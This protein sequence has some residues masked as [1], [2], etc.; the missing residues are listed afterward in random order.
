MWG[1]ER[2]LGDWVIPSFRRPETA[3]FLRARETALSPIETVAGAIESVMSGRRESLRDEFL[4]ALGVLMH[5]VDCYLA[6]AELR[7]LWS[8]RRKEL[9]TLGYLGV[10]Y[11]DALHFASLV[12]AIPSLP[13]RLV[14]VEPLPRF[15]AACLKT[16]ERLQSL[17]PKSKDVI[18][19][20]ARASAALARRVVSLMVSVHK[21]GSARADVG[22]GRALVRSV[23]ALR[24]DRSHDS[25]LE[26]LGKG[27]VKS[28]RG[29]PPC[30]RRRWR[31]GRSIPDHRHSLRLEVEH[32]VLAQLQPRGHGAATGGGAA[33]PVEVKGERLRLAGALATALLPSFGSSPRS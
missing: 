21:R 6:T 3:F 12:T 2:L 22:D 16:L 23:R 26:V 24:F 15:Y 31:P 14:F 5:E 33:S 19:R 32:E 29:G 27:Q 7:A 30:R 10:R 28:W 17:V 20:N 25:V 8:E 4:F 11:V 9:A 1:G 13:P 18:W